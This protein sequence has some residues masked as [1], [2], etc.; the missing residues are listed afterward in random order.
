MRT[1]GG[2]RAADRL[3]IVV[4]DEADSVARV[5]AAVEAVASRAGMG[6]D[7]IFE[8]KVAA[9]EAVANALAH[10]R[11]QTAAVTL[12]SHPDGVEIE[13]VGDGPFR[14]SGGLDASHGRGLLLIVGRPTR[15]SSPPS[16]TAPA[17]GSESG[18][19]RGATALHARRR[20][21]MRRA[22]T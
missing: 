7:G 6:G 4:R 17:C 1:Q 12:A 10:G 19:V 21:Y 22:P 3:A 5:R 13:I 16:R 8:L 20:R 14:G 18:P 11:G 15:S 9:T 2:N